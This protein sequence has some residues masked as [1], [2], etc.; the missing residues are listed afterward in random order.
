MA[1]TAESLENKTQETKNQENSYYSLTDGSTSISTSNGDLN[2]ESVGTKRNILKM[3]C[4]FILPFVLIV[5]IVSMQFIFEK[6]LKA[7][8]KATNST[9]KPTSKA[10][11]PG[12]G[13]QGNGRFFTVPTHTKEDT[14]KNVSNRMHKTNH[15]NN[16]D[17]C[18]KLTKMICCNQPKT[19]L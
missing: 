4:V 10:T 13:F 16:N 8:A 5:G 17:N 18:F 7:T 14:F 3:C 12:G 1:T 2:A 9:E 15:F 6:L 11:N 19:S